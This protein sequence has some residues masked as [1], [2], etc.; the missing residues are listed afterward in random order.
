MTNCREYGKTRPAYDA[1]H[2]TSKKFSVLYPNRVLKH[3][4]SDNIFIPILFVAD[5]KMVAWSNF[6]PK[7]KHQL[8]VIPTSFSKQIAM[9]KAE[10]TM[11][12]KEIRKNEGHSTRNER[13]KAR[14]MC[15]R[16][17]NIEPAAHRQHR[18]TYNEPGV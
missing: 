4:M 2:F 18:I 14:L 13:K 1:F 9:K 17:R 6:A 8:V 11:T 7:V 5:S 15:G 10:L 12:T 16:E 3:K